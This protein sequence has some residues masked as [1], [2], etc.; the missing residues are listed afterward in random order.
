M[1]ATCIL[2]PVCRTAD[3]MLS[4]MEKMQQ[5]VNWA[6]VL[7]DVAAKNSWFAAQADLASLQRL[8]A[9]DK[10]YWHGRLERVKAC[11]TFQLR[12]S[13]NTLSCN[14]QWESLYLLLAMV[15]DVVTMTVCR[16]SL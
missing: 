3:G 1:R 5:D 10:Q 8:F 15:S 12:S 14:M 6:P 9:Q 11:F 16:I 4:S 2:S 7:S 13:C